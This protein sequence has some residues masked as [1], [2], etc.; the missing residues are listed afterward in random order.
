MP[1]QVIVTTGPYQLGLDDQGDVHFVYRRLASNIDGTPRTE[2]LIFEGA[3]VPT[4]ITFDELR[5]RVPG[6]GAP[7]EGDG[8]KVA[9]CADHILVL[10]SLG[11]VAVGLSLRD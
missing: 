4:S 9:K 1:G 2:P 7:E 3:E 11:G 10:S 5:K 6:C 8:G